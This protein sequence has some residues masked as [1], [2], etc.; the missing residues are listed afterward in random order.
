M[1]EETKTKYVSF[2]DIAKSKKQMLTIMSP[3]T[4][5]SVEFPAFVVDYSDKYGVQWSSEESFGR[6]DPIKSYQSTTRNISIAVSVLAM[7]AEHGDRNF[8]E[9]SRL[10]RML[11]PVYSA[12][13]ASSGANA[14][15]ILAPPILDVQMMNYIYSP[16]DP[17][18]FLRGCISGLTF[19]PDFSIGHFI[20][21][22]GSIIPK[23]FDISFDFAPQHRE[24]LGYDQTGRFL[25]QNFPYD[26]AVRKSGERSNGPPG[27]GGNKALKGD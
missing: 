14:R 21:S 11:Y 24:T 12:P 27:N 9:Y 7:D 2:H 20:K 18:G 8:E 3:I 17:T 13:L 15:T 22:D 16:S 6:T 10:I 4:K 5:E 19:K 26:Q 25:R 23:K 1:T